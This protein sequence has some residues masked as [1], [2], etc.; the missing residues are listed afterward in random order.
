MTRGI[1]ALVLFAA[2]L[3]AQPA[4]AQ[5]QG[6]TVREVTRVYPGGP[7]EV[8][9]WALARTDGEAGLMSLLQLAP[10]A[11]GGWTMK[12]FRLVM[13][14]ATESRATAYGGPAPTPAIPCPASEDICGTEGEAK[15]LLWETRFRPVPGHRY[16]FAGPAGKHQVYTSAPHWTTRQSSVGARIVTGANDSDAVG[17]LGAG[18]RVEAFHTASAPG[19]KYGSGV[20]A[21]MPC[22]T[23]GGESAGSATVKSDGSDKA[24]PISCE[25]GYYAAFSATR[26]GRKWTATGPVVGEYL[27]PF[28]LF[29]FDYPKR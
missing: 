25:P 1:L 29:V 3:A 16:F 11:G 2:T 10:R 5:E 20:F 18:R 6:M 23:D 26:D 27:Y 4:P 24:V 9:L 12:T 21:M 17:A 22:D 14:N 19:G 15:M 28:R 7:R 8:T 13:Y